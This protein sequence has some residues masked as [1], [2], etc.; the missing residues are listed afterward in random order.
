MS[1]WCLHYIIYIYI[2][3]YA[4][5]SINH[6]LQLSEHTQLALLSNAGKSPPQSIRVLERTF[7]NKHLTQVTGSQMC[8][9]A[10]TESFP[11]AFRIHMVNT[12]H[13]SAHNT[14]PLLCAGPRDL[15]CFSKGHHH[16][17]LQGTS[18]RTDVDTE[19]VQRTQALAFRQ[20]FLF[21]EK[22]RR[23]RRGDCR[24]ICRLSQL[25]LDGLFCPLTGHNMKPSLTWY[26]HSL[27]LCHHV[28]ANE[29]E[30]I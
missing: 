26:H 12:A 14:P 5:V 30:Y 20:T 17:P 1:V 18:P 22:G 19:A 16:M 27:S 8:V 15:S 10:C 21:A 3:I 9:T 29:Q 13:G 25:L 7:I 4:T 24:K 23:E 6:D 2:Y 28:P 11:T